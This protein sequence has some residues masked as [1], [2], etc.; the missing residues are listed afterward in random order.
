[1]ENESAEVMWRLIEH[2]GVIFDMSFNYHYRVK[3]VKLMK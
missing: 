2:N 1:M 3:N